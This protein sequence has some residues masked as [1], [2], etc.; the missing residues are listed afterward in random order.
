MF[1]VTV[2][3]SL[4]CVAGV[5]PAEEKQAKFDPA[6]R[7]KIIAPFI[8]EQVFAVARVDVS[9]IEA[10]PLFAL[11]ANLVPAAEGAADR[12][13]ARTSLGELLAKLSKAGAKDVYFVVGLADVTLFGERAAPPVF[14]IV[15]LAARADVK[16]L[17]EIFA[18]LGGATER[19]DGVL[20]AGSRTTLERLQKKMTP[21]DRPALAGAFAAA[22]DT[23]VQAL[24]IPPRH[25]QRVIE[26][27]MPTLPAAIGG[28][29]SSVFTHGVRWAAVGVDPP[30]QFSL[31]LVIQSQDAD[32]AKA[33]RQKWDELAR[34]IGQ[35]EEVRRLAPNFAA[36]QEILTPKVEGDRLV[37][38]PGQ[39]PVLAA[40]VSAMQPP[41]EKARRAARRVASA[42]DLRQIATAMFM[43][44]EGHQQRLPA[45]AIQDAQ[46]K[47]LLSWRV[48][49][50]PYLGQDSLYKQFHL[51]EPWDSAHNR[52]LIGQMPAFYR[53]PGSKLSDKGLTNFFLPLGK[54]TV[55]PPGKEGRSLKE[56][57]T[58]PRIAV[59][60][61]DDQHAVVW[62]KPAD[63]AFDP[64]KPLTGLGGLYGNGFNAA[65][66]DGHVEFVSGATDA[67]AIREQFVLPAQDA[68]K[69]SNP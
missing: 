37:L 29:P 59:V 13:Q 66:S 4:I 60:E 34:I 45:P 61:V 44:A 16:V 23:A 14:A 8:D 32:A 65:F 54:N 52:T 40:L 31:K 50:L 39:K 35:D 43:Y 68:A 9:R 69:K 53:S 18:K 11:L 7:A 67:K 42:N 55:F 57:G 58:N 24:F 17:S 51:D 46:G 21:D 62:T 47:P 20:Y 64:D 1:R 2:L 38:A 28:G 41:L 22:G 27:M 63:L 49:L 12:Q 36:V 6:A 25:W 19:L 56:V 33:L 3:L 26:E 15:P 10:D 30:P 5:L 48:A